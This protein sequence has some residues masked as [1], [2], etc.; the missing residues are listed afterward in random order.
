MIHAFQFSKDNGGLGS[1]ELYPEEA[2]A[3]VQTQGFC[4]DITDLVV[5]PGQ[6]KKPL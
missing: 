3:E 4:A 2:M 5:I 6:E 1:E